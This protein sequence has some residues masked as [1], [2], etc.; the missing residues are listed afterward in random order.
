M[1]SPASLR[2]RSGGFTLLEVLISIVILAFGLLG[3]ASLQGS[4]HLAEVESYQRAQALL[5]LQ[6]F[7][8][9]IRTA[10]PEGASAYVTNPIP[11]GT[12]D[13]MPSD[14][15]GSTG[16]D[17]DKCEISQSLKGAAETK[18]GVN[19]GAMLGGRACVEQIQAADDSAGVCLA[20]IYRITVAWQGMNPTTSPTLACAQGVYGDD[21]LRRAV[22][23]I[24][25][26]GVPRCV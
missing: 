2:Y 21:R 19:V 15:S 24:V 23:T 13:G 18:A 1:L 10:D 6:D 14:C 5:I 16:T 7:T 22:S 26:L 17:R 11:L 12:G 9:R 20:G 8:D 4:V 3:L 25:T